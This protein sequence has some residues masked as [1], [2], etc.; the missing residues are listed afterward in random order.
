MP[1]DGFHSLREL[2]DE[3]QFERIRRVLVIASS[4]LSNVTERFRHF[5][6]YYGENNLRQKKMLYLLMEFINDH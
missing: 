2:V 4:R 5:S 6:F 3:M 1:S